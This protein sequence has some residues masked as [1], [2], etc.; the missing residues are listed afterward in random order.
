MTRKQLIAEIL[1]DFRQYDES[2]LI[3][4]RSLNRWIKNELKRF[5]ANIM[6]LTEKVIEV[7]NGEADLPENFYTLDLAVKCD[8]HSHEITQG[9]KADIQ[10]SSF[11]TQKIE[12]T[13]E[14]D[15]QSNSH[16][17]KDF[18]C[19]E[20]KVLFNNCLMTFRYS[21]PTVLRLTKGIKRE[22]CASSCKNFKAYSSPHEMNIIMNKMH[23]NF[24]K[25][26]VYLQYYG[27]PTDEEGDLYIPDVRSLE[28]YLIYYCKRK[29]LEN[30][31]GNDD[32]TTVGSKLGYF[33]QE[34]REN[35]GLAMT[36]T[37]MEALK[38]GWERRLKQK[39][40]RETNRYERMFP[41]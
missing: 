18:K 4:Y 20:E 12:T 28:E 31:M 34:E 25:G 41:N 14:W 3:D 16:V 7:K 37:K 9:C 23:F 6:T 8:S 5:G 35:F 22:Y 1:T 27:L 30:L 17:G 38:P 26:F 13:Y 36:Q 11:Y 32:D 19:I 39:M 15:N 29:I 2:G 33:R 24:N 40:I 10:S 21:N